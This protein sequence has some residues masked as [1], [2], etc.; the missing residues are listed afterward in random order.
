M[1]PVAPFEPAEISMEVLFRG[2]SRE[3]ETASHLP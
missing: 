2:V 3:S 1:F